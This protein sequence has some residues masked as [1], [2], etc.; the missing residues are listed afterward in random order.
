MAKHSNERFKFFISLAIPILLFA[1]GVAYGAG[2]I[3]PRLDNAEKRLENKVDRD[4]F[5]D[6]K[7]RLMFIEKDIKEIL[8]RL[9]R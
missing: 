3:I 7:R 2:A 1:L 6:V 8:S 9:P 5:N 4:S